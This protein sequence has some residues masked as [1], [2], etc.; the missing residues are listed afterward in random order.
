MANIILSEIETIEELRQLAGEIEEEIE[1]RRAADRGRILEQAGELAGQYDMSVEEFLEQPEKKRRAP[2]AVK[3]R[4]PDNP[5]QTWSGRGRQKAWVQ[6]ALAA[7]RS[8]EDLEV[9][10]G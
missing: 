3:Y 7:G 1:R 4:N 6:K 10:E 8:L 2:A 5:R 9:K